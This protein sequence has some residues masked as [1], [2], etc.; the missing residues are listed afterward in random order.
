MTAVAS[1]LSGTYLRDS[2][3][4]SLHAA[5]S[6]GSGFVYVVAS[7]CLYASCAACIHSI[8]VWETRRRKQL[9]LYGTT[10]SFTTTLTYTVTRKLYPAAIASSRKLQR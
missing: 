5:T 10:G 8:R 4:Q 9:Q 6:M 7:A 3:Q 2:L 1:G